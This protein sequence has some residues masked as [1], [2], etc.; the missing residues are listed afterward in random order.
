[1]KK[2]FLASVGF[3]LTCFAQ[4]S[5]AQAEPPAQVQ[6]QTQTSAVPTADVPDER[7]NFEAAAYTGVVI[8]NFAAQESNALIYPGG[9]AG[10]KN[11]YVV[12]IDFA[13]RL[14]GNAADVRALKGSQLWVYG[15]SIHG[16]QSGDVNCAQITNPAICSVLTAS[17]P[18]NLQN[19][20]YSVLRNATSL[21]A[22][23]GLRWEFL[24]LQAKSSDAVKLYVKSELGFLTVSGLGSVIQSDQKIALGAVVTSGRFKHSYWEAGWGKNDLFRTNPGRRFKLDGYLTWDLNQWMTQ[25][26]MTPFLEM[27]VDSDFGQGSDSVRSYFG[28]NFDLSKLWAPP[29][30]ISP[31][32]VTP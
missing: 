28:F 17:A 6:A 23:A 19:A 32:A 13:Y 29:A 4:A 16:E 12:G 7:G 14:I 20:F 2:L 11:S 22:Y 8:D 25:Y 10:I 3:A 26:G 18:A 5:P 30:K 24:T 27:T 1:M 15:E 31:A 9:A 21:E